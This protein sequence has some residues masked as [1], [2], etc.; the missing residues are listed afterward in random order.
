[1]TP[2]HL[3]CRVRVSKLDN[4]DADTTLSEE[5]T[6]FAL[7]DLPDVDIATRTKWA[8]EVMKYFNE[9]K[10]SL[11][12]WDFLAK[13]DGSVESLAV[14]LSAGP[15][16]ADEVYP[17]RFQI[18]PSCLQGLDNEQKIQRAEKFAMASLVYEIMSGVPPF[19]G[20][21]DDEVQRRFRTGDFPPD[22]ASLPN[23]LF[24]YSGW[25][26]E[27]SQA[28]NKRV[29]SEESSTLQAMTNYAK[30]HPYRT[31]IQVVGITLSVV[32]GLAGPVL[33]WA[34]F[35]AAGPAA[36]SAAAA[37]QASIGSV[38]AGSLFAWC[39]SAAMGGAALKGVQVAGYAGAALTKVKDVP[40]L[41]ETFKRE[42]HTEQRVQR[43]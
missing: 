5:P 34:G 1:M 25:S 36:G 37:W 32:S 4:E 9:S 38:Q 11:R 40:G 30:A 3:S 42:F 24:I 39:Q 16:S 22:A 6:V 18:P 14:P 8:F 2:V 17:A 28:L 31:G 15:S 43:R 27:F 13:L 21:T 35:T 20:L 33:G 19:E 10:A 41:L 7:K 26:D 29:K 23:S 12:S